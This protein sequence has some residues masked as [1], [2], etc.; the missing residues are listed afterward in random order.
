MRALA[1]AQKLTPKT[2]TQTQEPPEEAPREECSHNC[3][4]RTERGVPAIIYINLERLKNKHNYSTTYSN[5]EIEL[6]YKFFIK[7]NN[8]LNNSAVA[9]IP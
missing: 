5:L 8:N 2:Q 4:V 3:S 1:A 7:D 9:T 6:S